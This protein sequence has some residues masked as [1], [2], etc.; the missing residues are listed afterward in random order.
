ME[1]K[2]ALNTLNDIK[3]MMERSSKFKAISGLSIV[4]V[5][6]LASLVSAYIYFFLGDYHINTPSKWRT[7]IIVALVLLVVAFLTV[8]LMAYLKAKRHQL[9]FTMD[10]T[11]RRLLVNFFV[12]MLAGGLLCMSLLLQQHYGLISSITLIFYGLALIS[13]SH[14]SY[15][16]LRYLGYAELALGLIDC[17]LVDYALLTWF[18]GFGVLHIVFGIVF[19]LKYERSK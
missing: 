4:I 17:F 13:A 12:P 15:P 8:F 7:T 19:M 11:M 18:I 3:D 10:A 6:I 16:A 14:F 2:E 1:N 5:G 9:R